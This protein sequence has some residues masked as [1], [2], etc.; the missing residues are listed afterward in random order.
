VS[1]HPSQALALLAQILLIEVSG[2]ARVRALYQRTVSLNDH[3]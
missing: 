1:I 2:A 3:L